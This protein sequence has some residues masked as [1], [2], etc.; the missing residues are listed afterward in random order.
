MTRRE[1]RA[2]KLARII[3]QSDFYDTVLEECGELC[4]L[5][6]YGMEWKD[7]DGDTF[8]HVLRM[9]AKELGVERW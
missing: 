1:I 8:E 7:A 4:E 3:R 2:Q 5:A 6:G 9:A